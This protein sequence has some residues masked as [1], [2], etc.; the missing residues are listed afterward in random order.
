[1]LVILMS[2]LMWGLV[3]WSAD[4]YT[5]YRGNFHFIDPFVSGHFE[6]TL[7]A[8]GLPLAAIAIGCSI[9]LVFLHLRAWVPILMVLVLTAFFTTLDFTVGHLANAMARIGS[10]PAQTTI[11][12]T[13]E[14]ILRGQ[15]FAMIAGLAIV[16]LIPAALL[17]RS[18][19][20]GSARRF[21]KIRKKL[22]KRRSHDD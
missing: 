15:F 10:F 11:P 8:W 18:V 12:P 21:R 19:E 3:Y 2:L 22:R 9:R 20:R 17:R 7:G 1:M 16:G 4:L 6:T 5:D 14:M 13:S